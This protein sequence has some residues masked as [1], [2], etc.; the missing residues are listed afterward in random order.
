VAVHL[1]W[2]PVDVSGLP[3]V[4]TVPAVG[5]FGRLT[6]SGRPPGSGD[7]GDTSVRPLGATDLVVAG[8]EARV[9]PAGSN[10]D[11][12]GA[13]GTTLAGSDGVEPGA[14]VGALTGSPAGAVGAPAPA[15]G[16]RAVVAVIDHGPGIDPENVP[17]V[18][19]RFWRAD[20]SR[21]R[22]SGGTGLG[23][24]IVAA[25]VA[26]HGGQVVIRQT[27][28]GGATFVVQLPA[29]LGPVP[30]AASAGTVPAAERIG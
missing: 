23:L 25:V 3:G 12:A 16:A 18:F 11:H 30:P 15:H 1:E 17:H 2:A 13:A 9:A 27:P 20:Q 29:A 22:S 14:G 8:E 10:G 7:P 6:R 5:K 26:A 24:S 19:E 4:P 28:G 21:Q